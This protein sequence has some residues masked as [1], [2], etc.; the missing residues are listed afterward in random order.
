MSHF[1]YKNPALRPPLCIDPYLE[2]ININLQA[3]YDLSMEDKQKIK[4]VFDLIDFDGCGSIDTEE[5]DAA[6]F[7]LG[8]QSSDDNKQAPDKKDKP[9]ELEQFSSMMTGE[10]ASRSPFEDILIAFQVLSKQENSDPTQVF[11]YSLQK[12]TVESLRQTSQEF[13]M[14]FSDEEL[15]SMVQD[16]AIDGSSSINIHQFIE[17]MTHAPWF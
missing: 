4:D 2:K 13:Q 7:A 16:V 10:T 6:M 1:Y 17:I 3:K 9:M 15:L 14:V 12:I 8:Y 5:L 11:N